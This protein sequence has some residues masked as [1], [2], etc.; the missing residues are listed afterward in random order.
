MEMFI[1]II[2]SDRIT[3][4]DTTL[5]CRLCFL[6]VNCDK[7][8][9]LRTPVR[10]AFSYGIRMLPC[11]SMKYHLMRHR[12]TIKYAVSHM[13]MLYVWESASSL[14]AHVLRS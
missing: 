9:R 4:G 3:L 12:I 7:I 14:N 11:D 8:G 5:Q 10:E 2:T 1:Q 6:Q 13:K